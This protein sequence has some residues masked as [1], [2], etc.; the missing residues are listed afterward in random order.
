MSKNIL[1]IGF[2]GVGKGT[3]ARALLS[4]TGL[5]GIDTDDLIVSMEK[6]SVKK[7]FLNEGEE[8]FRDLEQKTA[9]WLQENVTNSIISTGGG[10]YNVDNLEQI[11]IVIYLESSFDGI[12]ERLKAHPNSKKKLK[13]RPLLSNIAHAKRIF[14]ERVPHYEKKAAITINVENKNLDQIINEILEEIK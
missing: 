1:L 10:F 4:E 2:M 12:L 9:K 11:G 8:Y 3:V 5:Y 13:K 7:I 6:R 14:D